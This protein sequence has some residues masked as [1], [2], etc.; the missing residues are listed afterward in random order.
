MKMMKSLIGAAAAIALSGTA[1]TAV[2]AEDIA[3]TG[4][5]A[6]TNGGK[7]KVENAT[8]LMSDGKIV[9][10]A[11]GGDVPSGYR[12]VDA[13]GKWV[14][15][16]FMAASGSI[17]LG[18]VGSWADNSDASAAKAKDGIALDVKYGLNPRNTRVEIT[19]IEGVTHALSHFSSAKDQWVGTGAVVR[20]AGDTPGEMIIK[21]QAMIYLD[22]D[23]GSARSNGGS[24]SVLWPAIIKKLKD[25]KPKDEAEKE[26]KEGD[27]KKD[28]KPKEK[29]VAE[30]NLAA[31]FAGDTSLVVYAHR[32]TDIEQAIALKE[33]FGFKVI[34]MGAREAWMVAD[35]LAAASIPVVL[36]PHDNLPSRFDMLASTGA[37]AAR[38]NAAGV[39]IAFSPVD[40]SNTRLLPQA[41]GNA[42]AMGLP[43]EAAV[44]AM[45]VNPAEIFG[46]SGTYG[47]M[48]TGKDADVVVWNGD[49]LE[50][51][52]SPDAVF[53][54]GEQ[55]PL[56]SRQTKLRDRYLNI[57]RAP[58]LN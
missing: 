54:A 3:I 56:V 12:T 57:P 39:K 21:N 25:A 26:D 55:I 40:T 1:L 19:R 33:M 32:V 11:S 14:T 47:T 43:W 37:N 29:S 24:R 48:A 10:V 44:D 5:T 17:G 6:Y 49:P 36:N 16:G 4:G 58:G 22:A 45:T 30:K 50:L 15:T 53:I 41:A 28:K 2:S 35:K 7:G 38:L 34:V 31:L 27:D 46:V 18:E 8:I 51:M 9:S 23:E 52:T 20:L 13:S 42:V